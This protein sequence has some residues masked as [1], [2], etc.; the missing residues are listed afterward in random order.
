MAAVQACL[1]NWESILRS[2]ASGG[3]ALRLALAL[4]LERFVRSATPEIAGRAHGV[5]VRRARHGSG[6]RGPQ[7]S[8]V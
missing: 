5:S 8:H 6:G 3:S 1:S 2:E 7:A 4:A